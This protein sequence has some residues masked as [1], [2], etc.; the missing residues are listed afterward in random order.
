MNAQ[1]LLHLQVLGF[2]LEG[3]HPGRELLLVAVGGFRVKVDSPLEVL[4]CLS[5]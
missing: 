4:I 2:L 5:F 1:V 3:L